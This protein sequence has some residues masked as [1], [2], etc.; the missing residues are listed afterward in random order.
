[1][2]GFSEQHG[3]PC[4]TDVA[5]LAWSGIDLLSKTLFIIVLVQQFLLQDSGCNNRGAPDGMGDLM[6]YVAVQ[7][8]GEEE[9]RGTDRRFL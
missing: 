8:K 6:R 5:G 9:D 2:A 1:M 7:G 4:S 3:L